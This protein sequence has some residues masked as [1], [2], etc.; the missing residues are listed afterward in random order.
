MRSTLHKLGS[1]RAKNNNYDYRSLWCPFP[2]SLY[3]I[4]TKAYKY[5]T[6]SAKVLHS[7][8]ELEQY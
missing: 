4:E 6:A 1:D 2:D 7:N 8:C 3:V 5:L